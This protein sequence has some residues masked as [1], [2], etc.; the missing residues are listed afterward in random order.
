[1]S[2][3]LGLE[4][5]TFSLRAPL[6]AVRLGSLVQVGRPDWDTVLKDCPVGLVR[7]WTSLLNTGKLNDLKGLAKKK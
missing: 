7:A 6:S 5:N 2:N 4:D 1:M 3:I